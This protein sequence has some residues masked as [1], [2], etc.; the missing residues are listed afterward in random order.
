MKKMILCVFAL[1]ISIN[2]TMA[3]T[4]LAE[5][6]NERKVASA[7][8]KTE[9]KIDEASFCCAYQHYTKTTTVNDSIVTDRTEAI[10]EVGEQVAKYGDSAAYEGE[11]PEGF[12]SSYLPGDPRANDNFTVY[13][14]Y[15]TSGGLTVREALLPGAYLYSEI[16]AFKWEFLPGEDTLLGYACQR[17]K[18]QYGGRTWVVSFAADIPVSAGP[19]KLSGLPGLIL[20]AESEDSIHRFVA[21]AIFKVENQAISYFCLERDYKV[22]CKD[23]ILFRN[24]LKMD[25][26]WA[27][28][29]AYYVQAGEIRSVAVFKGGGK[30]NRAKSWV[31]NG[32]GLPEEG[33]F[34]RRYQPLELK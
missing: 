14:N 3:Q 8:K 23:F 5:K 22:A 12:S 32:I 30:T 19:W 9:K 33:G 6:E 28:N 11:R 2:A 1:F 17:A 16:P 10:L 25:E 20:K 18:V 29:A 34:G 21:H 31:I 27:K 13:Q 15:P 26:R 24:R 4:E 7:D